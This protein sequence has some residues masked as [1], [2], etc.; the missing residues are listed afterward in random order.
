M[1]H[2][3]SDGIAEILEGGHRA[4]LTG[5]QRWLELL[6]RRSADRAAMAQRIAERSVQHDLVHRRAIEGVRTQVDA[7]SGMVDEQAIRDG[8]W[9]SSPQEWERAQL[10]EALTQNP[11][12]GWDVKDAV[13]TQARILG[14]WKIDRARHHAFGARPEP[15]DDRYY[16]AWA[17]MEA[18]DAQLDLA[19]ER[20]AAARAQAPIGADRSPAAFRSAL[21]SELAHVVTEDAGAAFYTARDG[22]DSAAARR[23][24][25][26]PT[27]LTAADR[28]EEAGDDVAELRTR[29][30][31]DSH[32]SHDFRAARAELLAEENFEPDVTEAA[33]IN[34]LAFGTPAAEAATATKSARRPARSAGAAAN[35]GTT[36]QR[37]SAGR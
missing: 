9:D 36:R 7:G 3:E 25:Q 21:L 33:I 34:D 37:S 32:D 19:E 2:P 27:D 29:S 18:T 11:A 12:S 8:V 16:R 24:A 20:A 17:A 22:R 13:E 10:L 1:T 35:R 5:V 14:N 4:M 31:H 26:A 30:L 15:F 23:I 28:L 6:G